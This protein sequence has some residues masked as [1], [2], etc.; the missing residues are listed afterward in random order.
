MTS[1]PD[2]PPRNR[3]Q[4]THAHALF[5]SPRVRIQVTP[6]QPQRGAFVE[7]MG[8]ERIGKNPPSETDRLGPLF[9]LEL[10]WG[11]RDEPLAELYGRLEDLVITYEQQS[12]GTVRP[13]VYWRV[14]STNGLAEFGIEYVLSMQT[15]RLDS[16]PTCAIASQVAG[17]SEVLHAG[18]ES[19][20]E[21]SEPWVS[22]DTHA[23]S[24]ASFHAAEGRP[25]ALFRPEGVEWSYLEMLYPGDFTSAQCGPV[26]PPAGVQIRWRLF[27]ES[28][29]KGVIRRARL[30]GFVI[31]RA[32]DL[33]VAERLWMDFLVSE[34]PLTT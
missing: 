29:E 26:S 2:T 20:A 27:A 18:N 24:S 14:L 22:L 30:R 16:T 28:L 6:A 7:R 11:E 34:L 5:Q 1:T 32:N 33:E 9:Q 10:P 31:P 19:A 4:L 3:W 8:V 25:C 13:Q 12:P 15:D 17:P 21:S 23:G